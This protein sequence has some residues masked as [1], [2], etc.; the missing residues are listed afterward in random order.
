[1]F[2]SDIILAKKGPL[3]KIWLA[4]HWDKKISK[5][6]VFQ[7]DIERSAPLRLS[8]H[9]LLGLVR[10]YQ[11]KV[12]YLF[13][14]CSEAMV[15]IRM[16]FRPGVVDLP[17]EAAAQQQT[18]TGNMTIAE[19]EMIHDSTDFEGVE[20]QLDEWMQTNLPAENVSRNVDI[21]LEI[22][23]RA[24]LRGSRG[25]R[26]SQ[27][28]VGPHDVDSDDEEDEPA[29]WTPFDFEIGEGG[30]G[31]DDSS[32]FD[33]KNSS[34]GVEIGRDAEP[35]GRDS[36]ARL[37]SPGGSLSKGPAADNEGKKDVNDALNVPLD[38]SSIASV[39]AKQ[40]ASPG[41]GL[42]PSR[43]D[44]P[45][46]DLKVNVGYESDDADMPL[47]PDDSD[48]E[49]DKE[50]PAVSPSSHAAKESAP[51]AVETVAV[52]EEI[53]DTEADVAKARKTKKRKKRVAKAG[54]DDEEEAGARDNRRKRRRAGVLEK[55]MVLDDD[56]LRVEDEE[57][58]QP[59]V[60]SRRRLAV[61]AL[62]EQGILA[63]RLLFREEPTNLEAALSLWTV[64]GLSDEIAASLAAQTQREL[65]YPA[66]ERRK[67]RGGKSSTDGEEKD[68]DDDDD[69]DDHSMEEDEETERARRASASGASDDMIVD[70]AE[71]E[72]PLFERRAS[73]RQSRRTSTVRAP[74]LKDDGGGGEASTAASTGGLEFGV[75]GSASVPETGSVD[76]AS[77]KGPGTESEPNDMP[78]I[79]IED[80]PMPMPF[81]DEASDSGNKDDADKSSDEESEEESDGDASN[82]EEPTSDSKWHKRTANMLRLCRTVLDDR[83]TI[84]YQFLAKNKNKRTVAGCFFEI[85]QLKTWDRID[86]AQDEPY[87][88]IQIGRGPKFDD[89]IPSTTQ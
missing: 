46:A 14:D 42:T 63:T 37:D 59:R 19:F 29:E 79:D 11:R 26:S 82:V 16:A 51:L 87:G 5:A 6:Q 88:L 60:L 70:I 72:G 7:T 78:Q 10:I 23:P 56:E 80:E 57:H 89:P 55:K 39:E 34:H 30:V 32:A 48:R 50:E 31:G 81:S 86:L 64:A 83:D 49:E 24:N 22:T 69:D 12:K 20:P 36:I 65:P 58:T 15:K 8:G 3:G 73:H 66:R 85:L 27:G 67:S 54:N 41:A 21:T 62:E 40:A 68:G 33:S 74:T 43:E 4:A 1:M 47:V 18:G 25:S 53:V 61:R 13:T 2:Y 76:R 44:K 38:T 45:P 84:T 35:E 75:G 77:I 28:S 17:Y 9:L 71:E 52:T